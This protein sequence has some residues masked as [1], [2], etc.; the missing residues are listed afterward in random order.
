MFNIKCMHIY[1]FIGI[2]AS[3]STNIDNIFT[4]T[5]IS[6]ISLFTVTDKIFSFCRQL[7]WYN[8]TTA[9]CIVSKE[10][11]SFYTFNN[12]FYIVFKYFLTVIKYLLYLRT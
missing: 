4:V 6:T 11:I 3:L 1:I 9:A 12:I 10:G 8:D 7:V 2:I 5:K